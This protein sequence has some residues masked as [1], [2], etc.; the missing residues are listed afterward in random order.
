LISKLIEH[1]QTQFLLFCLF[2]P[3]KLQSICIII[4]SFANPGKA[5]PKFILAFGKGHWKG[6]STFTGNCIPKMIGNHV[7]F[8]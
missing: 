5:V 2:I 1:L 7:S 8:L 3:K 4:L 6:M